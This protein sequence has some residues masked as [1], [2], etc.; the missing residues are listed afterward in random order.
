[1]KRLL[2]LTAASIAIVGCQKAATTSENA[3]TMAANDANAAAPDSTETALVTAN[4]TTPGTFEVT[5]KD[6]TK[7]QTVLNADGTYVDSDSSGKETARGTWNVTDGKTCFDPE[8]DEGPTCWT[9]T[10]AGADGSFTATSDKGEETGGKR[11]VASRCIGGGEATAM[12]VEPPFSYR[13]PI[14]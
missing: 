13:T 9:E 5:A 8:G 1:M 10:P 11:G 2:L 12:A 6:G 3:D 7:A 4:G 14:C